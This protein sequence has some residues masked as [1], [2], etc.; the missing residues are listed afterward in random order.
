[1]SLKLSLLCHD[2]DFKA[3]SV[4]N[5]FCVQNK[6]PI[7]SI[8]IET[9]KKKINSNQPI[10]WKLLRKKY[11]PNFVKKIC[12]KILYL[13]NLESMFEIFTE[14][15]YLKTISVK[16]AA[17]KLKIPFYFTENHSSVETK[18]ILESRVIDYAI[19]ISSNYLIKDVLLNISTK[20]INAHCALLPNHRSLDSL[21]WSVMIGDKLGITTHFVDAGIDTGDILLFEQVN[22]EKNDDLISFR[23]KLDEYIPEVFYKTII[24]LENNEII[25][26]KQKEEDGIKHRIMTKDEFDSA[27]KFFKEKYIK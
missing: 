10:T 27:Q 26:K 21:P 14:S 11:K 24:K 7:D 15:K 3:L 17:K 22:P 19:L 9:S 5:C 23:R 1:M 2:I 4:L 6:Y 20:I 12:A 13:I 16:R 8:I 18:Q 25:P